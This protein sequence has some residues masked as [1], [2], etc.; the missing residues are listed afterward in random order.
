MLASYHIATAFEITI[1]SGYEPGLASLSASQ[2]NITKTQERFHSS[3]KHLYLLPPTIVAREYY[4]AYEWYYCGH[5]HYPRPV[6][7]PYL[8][9]H[10][11]FICCDEYQNALRHHALTV[12]LEDGYNNFEL[13]KRRDGRPTPK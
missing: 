12:L 5:C 9:E 11:S 6:S 8:W 10:F 2:R 13:R 4:D 1:F 7:F 3:A